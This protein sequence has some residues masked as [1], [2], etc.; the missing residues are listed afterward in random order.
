M[1]WNPP[2]PRGRPSLCSPASSCIPVRR[3][4]LRGLIRRRPHNCS[5][6]SWAWPLPASRHHFPPCRRSFRNMRRRGETE[7]RGVVIIIT[8]KCLQLS[9]TH[10]PCRGPRTNNSTCNNRTH[11]QHTHT[12]ISRSWIDAHDRG[13]R[14]QHAGASTY[15]PLSNHRAHPGVPTRRASAYNTRLSGTLPVPS[16]HPPWNTT[17]APPGGTARLLLS[18]SMLNILINQLPI[19]ETQPTTEP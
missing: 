7:E 1:P 5:A 17:H 19:L 10:T 13:P 18:P 14:P 12:R 15:S 16:S 9:S 6:G 3:G 8:I 4:P 2:L 11:T